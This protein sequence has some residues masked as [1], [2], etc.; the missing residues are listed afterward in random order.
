MPTCDFF[1]VDCAVTLSRVYLFFVMKVGSRHIHLPGVSAHPDGVWTVQQAQNL[2]MGLGGS[3]SW[4]A[5][6]RAGS[7]QRS[8]PCS[9]LPGSGW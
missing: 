3:V 2:L 5:L 7:P 1:H 4:C 8:M 9:R 6:G